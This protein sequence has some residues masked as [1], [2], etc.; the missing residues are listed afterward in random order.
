MA[1]CFRRLSNLFARQH[2]NMLRCNMVRW[3]RGNHEFK[4]SVSQPD[5]LPKP[6]VRPQPSE[7]E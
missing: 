7:C 1:Q 5:Q 3:F 4:R 2:V 6:F